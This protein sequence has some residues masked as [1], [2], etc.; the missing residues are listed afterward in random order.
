MNSAEVRTLYRQFLRI[1]RQAVCD[2]I[3]AK[4]IIRD[5]IR[6]AFRVLPPPTERI[7]N[8][9]QFLVRAS[10]R[11]GL[12]HAILKNLCYLDKSKNLYIK[13]YFNKSSIYSRRTSFHIY[14]RRKPLST[15]KEEE[16]FLYKRIYDEPDLA[17]YMINETCGLCL[18]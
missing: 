13:R 8:T 2:S 10:K 11:K 3:P 9:L 4:Y 12:E 18:R 7:N 15:M 16:K 1:G 14:R 5:K 6:A 17:I